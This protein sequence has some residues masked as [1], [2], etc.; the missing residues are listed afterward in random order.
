MGSDRTCWAVRLGRL[1]TFVSLIC[2]CRGKYDTAY[3]DYLRALM[4]SMTEHGLVAYIVSTSA[5]SIHLTLILG[6]AVHA[7]RRLVPTHRRRMFQP[8]PSQTRTNRRTQS[9]APAWTLHAAGL[10]SD[11]TKLTATGAAYVHGVTSRGTVAEGERGLWPT[12]YT[13]L[14]CATM[15]WVLARHS[16][17][18]LP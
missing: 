6:I 2:R 11:P 4:E 17:S 10:T 8:F 12:G 1:E 18:V 3:L 5:F 13:K 15:K 14:A 9:G 16:F 7:P